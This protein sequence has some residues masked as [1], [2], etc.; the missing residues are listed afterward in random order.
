MAQ[1]QD[2]NAQLKKNRT[3]NY[4]TT[5]KTDSTKLPN[6]KSLKINLA[7]LKRDSMT[8]KCFGMTISVETNYHIK[9]DEFER[10]FD[11]NK[12]HCNEVKHSTPDDSEQL[13]V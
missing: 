12:I 6:K 5:N 8:D 13:K 7:Y 2:R 3:K 1:I 9:F 11:E 4:T 10:I